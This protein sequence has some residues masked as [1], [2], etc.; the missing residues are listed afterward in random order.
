M[1]IRL[2]TSD[3]TQPRIRI[4]HSSQKQSDTDMGQAASGP[5]AEAVIAMAKQKMAFL[6]PLG[7]ANPVRHVTHAVGERK[8]QASLLRGGATPPLA[9]PPR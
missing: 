7:A 5:S 8:G 6:P 2:G 1:K 3:A 9:G 4:P